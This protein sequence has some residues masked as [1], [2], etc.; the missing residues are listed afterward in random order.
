[1]TDYRLGLHKLPDMHSFPTVADRAGTANALCLPH[2]NLLRDVW[3]ARGRRWR[4][5]VVLYLRL[6]S[7]IGSGIEWRLEEVDGVQQ[8]G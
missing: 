4:D 1:M 8:A 5:A 2:R 3:L 6:R 7:A